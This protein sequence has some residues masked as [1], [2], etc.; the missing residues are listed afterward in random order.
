M[1]ETRRRASIP[2]PCLN[3]LKQNTMTNIIATL[4]A[5]ST[6]VLL[7]AGTGFVLG[8]SISLAYALARPIRVLASILF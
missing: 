7:T 8:V 5:D 3:Q 2:S 6:F 1:D 4:P